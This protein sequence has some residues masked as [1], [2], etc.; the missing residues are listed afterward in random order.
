MKKFLALALALVLTLSVAVVA[1]ADELT[2]AGSKDFKIDA[3]YE[4]IPSDTLISI[5][6]AWTAPTLTYTV[7]YEWDK[8]AH[9]DVVKTAT[10]E[11]SAN[12][13]LSV[14]N[15]SSIAI[16][17][18]FNVVSAYDDLEVVWTR[19][20]QTENRDNAEI[21][22]AAEDTAAVPTVLEITDV[23]YT[24]ETPLDLGIEDGGTATVA[25]I[26]LTVAPAQP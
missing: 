11:V 12:G 9:K 6:L 21:G 20:G 13:T 19:D 10:W 14:A 23:N 15:D 4:E 26:T 25:T 8:E 5:N 22:V 2:E 1:F 7:E 16:D 18:S 3:T 24:G 17:V